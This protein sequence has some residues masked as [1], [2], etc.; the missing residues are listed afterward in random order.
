MPIDYVQRF[1]DAL[2][3]ETECLLGLCCT[4]ALFARVYKIAWAETAL[5]CGQIHL[6]TLPRERKTK[7]REPAHAITHATDEIVL[8]FDRLVTSIIG[9][10]MAAQL[11]L[12][13]VVKAN[14]SQQRPVDLSKIGH[15][16]W[17]TTD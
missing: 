10:T 6:P 17:R 7:S 16:G 2:L 11:V 3:R 1:L 15:R 13:A 5:L 8:V 12:S 9:S 14:E 4:R